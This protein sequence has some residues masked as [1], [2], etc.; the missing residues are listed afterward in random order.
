MQLKITPQRPLA[1]ETKPISGLFVHVGPG[2]DTY[3]R[4]AL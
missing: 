4:I 2:E 3:Q 1:V